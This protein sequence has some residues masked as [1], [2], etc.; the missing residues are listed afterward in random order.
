[1]KINALITLI[2]AAVSSIGALMAKLA[3]HDALLV[4]ALFVLLAQ[5]HAQRRRQER[6]A[7]QGALLATMHR[8]SEEVTLVGCNEIAVRHPELQCELRIFERAVIRSLADLHHARPH[9]TP[10][11]VIERFVIAKAPALLDALKTYDDKL[12]LQSVC[13]QFRL[14]SQRL[15]PQ[16]PASIP[17]AETLF[18][19]SSAD[20]SSERSKPAPPSRVQPGPVAVG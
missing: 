14:M 10:L 8:L 20:Q 7:V 5:W 19:P 9:A 4:V 3:Q 16:A 15:L 13:Q 18:A 1:M 12:T 6:K 2:A 17:S 11:S